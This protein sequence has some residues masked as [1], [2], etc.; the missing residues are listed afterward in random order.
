MFFNKINFVFILFLQLIFF[1]S[2]VFSQL[3]QDTSKNNQYVILPVI[4]VSPEFGLAYGISTSVAFKTSFKNDSLTRNSVI[5]GLG[6]LTTNNQNIQALDV[7]VF[8]PK[9]KYIFLFQGYHSYF[10]D[11]FWGIGPFT[12]DQKYEKYSLEQLYLYPHLK[13]KIANQLFVGALYEFQTILNIN[14]IKNGIFDTSVFEGKSK[15]HVSG[16]GLSLN[17]DSRDFTFYPSK[18]IFFNTQFTY[19]NK[20]ITFSDFNLLKWIVDFRYYKTLFKDN[21]IAVQ[22]YNYQTFGT[23]PYKELAS[24]GGQNNMRGFYQGRYRAKNMVTLLGE[25]RTKL[26]GRF[27]GVIFGGFGEVYNKTNELSLSS[28]K[29]SVGAG[30]RFA[31]LTKEKLN[32]RLDY[33]YSNSFNQSLYFTF[34]ECF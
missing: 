17:Y 1:N 12:S 32:L 5:Q 20:E 26:I 24:F 11:K 6:F 16:L 34:V 22:L 10:P 33:G 7:L 4:F 23:I 30:I 29:Y 15:Y 8:S 31:L 25:Y 2:T 9:E 18:G 3:N 14:Y 19:Y 21:I 13:K 28:I 27:N